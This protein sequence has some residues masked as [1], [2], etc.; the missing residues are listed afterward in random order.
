M[1]LEGSTGNRADIED[2]T[3]AR[4]VLRISPSGKVAAILQ[5]KIPGYKY[6][7]SRSAYRCRIQ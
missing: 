5:H 1:D 2:D 4:Q 3:D 6:W 7:G